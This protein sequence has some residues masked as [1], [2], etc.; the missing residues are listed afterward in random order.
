MQTAIA[1][2]DRTQGG[3]AWSPPSM[4]KLTPRF[5]TMTRRKN[6]SITVTIGA[7]LQ[8][9]AQQELLGDLVGHQR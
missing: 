6:P 1:T 8:Q 5:H 4:P 3:S 2:A 9:V 7:G